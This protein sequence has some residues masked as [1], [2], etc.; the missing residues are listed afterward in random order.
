MF[1]LI[2]W[3]IV[4]KSKLLI[5]FRGRNNKL[6]HKASLAYKDAIKLLSKKGFAKVDSMT[7]REFASHVRTSGGNKYEL[8]ASFTEKYLGI[9]YGGRSTEKDL[10]ELSSIYN[11]LKKEIGDI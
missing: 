5:V 3:V 1:A 11:E 7:Q 2:M 6:E 4:A 10:Q 9:R 8:V